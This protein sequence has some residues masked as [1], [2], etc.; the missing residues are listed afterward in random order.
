LPSL[1]D[2]V[3]RFKPSQIPWFSVKFKERSGKVPANGKFKGGTSLVYPK[4][5]EHS[6]R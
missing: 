6:S 4:S 1:R 2:A 3:G 5:H